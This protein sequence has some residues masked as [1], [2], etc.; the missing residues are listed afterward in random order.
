MESKDEGNLT[1][2]QEIIFEKYANK[3]GIDK[4]PTKDKIEKVKR[5]KYVYELLSEKGTDDTAI[6]KLLDLT[7][8]DIEL[9]YSMKQAIENKAGFMIALWGVLVASMIQTDM[10]LTLFKNIMDTSL[11][12]SI[13]I[14]NSII[15]GGLTISGI[16]SLMHIILVL[17]YNPYSKFL[18]GRRDENFRCAVE[19]KNMLLV[20]L[21]DSNTTVWEKNEAANEK[22]YSYLVKHV[23]WMLL[24]VAFIILGFCCK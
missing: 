12:L 16:V 11:S 5:E 1:D 20:K 14:G 17:L 4:I 8:K 19:D 3:Y 13:R 15:L 18:F 6:E 23:I 22:K 10:L 7:I 24:F 21:L 2:V 9:Q